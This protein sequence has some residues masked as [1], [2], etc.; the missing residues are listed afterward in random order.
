VSD[1]SICYLASGRP[2]VA[3][4]TGVTELLPTGAGLLIVTEPA[5]AAEAICAVRR[6]PRRHQV[7][8]RRLAEEFFDSSKVL[9]ALADRVGLS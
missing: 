5:E 9:G 6:E 8:A 3:Q 2:V 7:A 1:R 4:D